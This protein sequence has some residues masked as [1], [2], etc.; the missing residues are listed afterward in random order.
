MRLIGY[1]P[2]KANT[3]GISCGEHADYGMLTI[4]HM[5][6]CKASLQVKTQEGEWLK[7]SP[8]ENCFV[9]NIGD[10]LTVMTNGIYKSTLHR[11]IHN[12]DKYR[13]SVPFFFEPR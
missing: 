12:G 13:T 6:E 7:V 2:L 5:N 8:I 4:L 3:D 1:P 9:V 11:V 10:M